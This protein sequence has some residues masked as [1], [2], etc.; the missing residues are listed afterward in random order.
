MTAPIATRQL[1]G[2][3]GRP[4]LAAT[5][6]V[7]TVVLLAEVV[8]AVWTG[9]LALLV[10]AAHMLADVAGLGLALVAAS[11]TLRPAT[12][13]HTWGLRRVE[14]LVATGQAAILLVVGIFAFVDGI[15]RLF[16]PPE[17]TARPLMAFGVLGLVA[18]IVSML[19]LR[20]ARRGSLN[21]RAAFLE[22]VADTLGSLAVI[23]GAVAILTTGWVGAD[24]VAGILI[25]VL[26]I[27]RAVGIL[28]EATGILLESTPPGLN[29]TEVRQHILHVPHVR[30]VHDLHASQ[31]ASGL[32]VISAH[33]VVDDSCFR[34]G[35]AAAILDEIQGCLAAHFPVS[36]EH[37]TLQLELADHAGHEFPAHS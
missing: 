19:I 1:G 24:A 7:T 15:Q 17:I 11:L 34:D 25:A 32:P 22:V 26:I 27:P 18:N 2:R 36:V 8:G 5:L 29:L 10:D 23:V 37:S 20:P 33:V 9:S 30:D 6:S 14:V 28:R 4:R 13:R 31:I 35:H 3:A 12:P 21:L 16:Q